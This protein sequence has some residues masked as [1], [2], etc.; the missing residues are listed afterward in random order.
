MSARVQVKFMRYMPRGEQ[1]VQCLCAR[2]EAVVIFRAAIKINLQP[3]KI[4]RARN[5][6]GIVLIPERGI[7]RRTK[8]IAENAQPPDLA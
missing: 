1:F 7:E 5:R 8:R 2:I 3:G 6:Y 4:R